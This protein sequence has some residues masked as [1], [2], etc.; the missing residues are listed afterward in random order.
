MAMDNPV[1][2]PP[3]NDTSNVHRGVVSPRRPV[4]VLFRRGGIGDDGEL[5]GVGPSYLC[6]GFGDNDN[7]AEHPIFAVDDQQKL[8]QSS[9]DRYLCFI[10]DVGRG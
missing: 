6:Y 4:K 10:N 8:I 9:S 2:F 7:D 3:H 5:P 1:R